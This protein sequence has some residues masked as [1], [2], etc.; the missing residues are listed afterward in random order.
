VKSKEPGC[1]VAELPSCFR[2]G[3]SI[4]V[5]CRD[6]TRWEP[7]AN[8]AVVLAWVALEGH[9]DR[10]R[11]SAALWPDSDAAQAR[12]NLRVLVHRINQK[13]GGELLLGAEHLTLDTALAPLEAQDAD[14][15]LAALSEGGAAR[16]ELLAEAGADASAGEDLR[17][18]LEATRLRQRQ[19]H[20]AQLDEA[21]A[22]ALAS[23]AQPRALALARAG[24]QLDPLSEHRHRRL[25]EVLVRGGDRAAALAAYEACKTVL[26]Q[27]LGVLPGLQTRTVQL[28]ILQ[29]QVLGP[30][31][32]RPQ[33]PEAD[34]LTTL[35]GAARYPLVERE[36]LLVQAQAALERGLHVVVQGEPGVGKTRLLRHL[37]AWAGGDAEPVAIRSAL[38]Q[39][40]YAA[41]AQLLQEV[42]ARRAPPI[43]MPEQIELARLAPLAF[44]GVKPSDAP[45]SVSRLHA[46]LRH[47]LARLGGVGV[48]V[49]V[50]DDVHDADAASQ[51]ALAALLQAPPDAAS[52][53]PALLLG[54]RS[55]EVEPV[56]D[57]TVTDSQTR[58]RVQRIELPRLSQAGV[59]TLLNAMVA[60]RSASE[61]APQALAQQLHKQTGG[62]P[63]FVIELA[64]Q[65]LEQG[66]AADV[67]S[68]QALLR[69]G[70]LRC[71]AIAQQL[72]AVAAVAAEDF[73]VELAVSVTGQP[74]LALMPAWSEL[75]QRGLFAGHGLAHDLVQDAVLAGLPEAIR[76]LLHRQLAQHL[77]DQGM[78]GAPVLRHWQAAG[79][80]DRA[81]P[82]AV[83]QLYAV[84]AAGLSAL[85]QELEIVRLL[86][87]AS[88]AVLAAHLWLTAELDAGL[89]GSCG[90]SAAPAEMEQ[91]R[92]ALRQRVDRGPGHAAHAAWIAYETAHELKWVGLSKRAAYEVLAPAAERMPTRGIERAFVEKALVYLALGLTGDPR[93]HLR[94]ASEAVVALPHGPCVQRVRMEL[95]DAQGMFLD[96][97]EG[98]CTLAARARASRRR[99][100]LAAVA[101]CRFRMGYMQAVLGNASHALRH[102]Q[103]AARLQA[104]DGNAIEPYQS[105]F[106][107]GK[108]ALHAGRYALADRLLAQGDEPAA[109]QTRPVYRAL[110]YLRLGDMAQAR[111][112]LGLV[113]PDALVFFPA[114]AIHTHVRAQLD[115]LEGK[116]P[117]PALRQQLDEAVARGLSGLNRDLMAWELV[118]R[119]Q[120]LATRLHEAHALLRGL[121][122]VGAS[123]ARQQVK[124]LLEIAEACAEA[125]D[126]QAQAL[127]AQA[128]RLLRRGYTNQTLYLPEGLV[129][130]ARLIR[131][132]DP[133]EADALVQVARRWVHGALQ[134]LPAGARDP[135]VQH[136]AVNRLLLGASE[137]A[138]YAAPLC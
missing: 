1:W 96:H 94:R 73:T 89:G 109:R 23:S 44:A 133:R 119:T 74:A 113:G 102:Y 124:A 9:A 24:V 55:G 98:L 31:P 53:S 5:V 27:H 65:A 51:A 85:A 22:Q 64:R 46:A 57:N 59:Q 56:L 36:T 19:A 116:D 50:L 3:S 38:K 47:W 72:A 99:G 45:L 35:G 101:N 93:L 132:H 68:L 110:L 33:T 80:A 84:N 61:R 26:R 105:P 13:F 137:P 79:D 58:H 86:E 103:Q 60:A 15:I 125:G 20:L 111:A 62:N 122:R 95:E 34:G 104:G 129:R 54:H 108:Y 130:C 100:D 66:E 136:V 8:A 10:R 92:R 88:D 4:E 112:Q 41:V 128:A 77:E 127:I 106:A 43:E 126:A 18:W 138:L 12:S 42:Q 120:P 21:L 49:L 131:P 14:A 78:R 32:V 121:Q 2:V 134:H 17:A 7:K 52:P 63:L 70:L 76:H 82:H 37:A 25:M 91:R 71:G 81:L 117:V 87:R 90:G 11:L 75:Q 29:E 28:R 97:V 6:G 135:F 40:P 69:A 123:G 114:Q 107:V 118:Q 83:H 48:R 30:A 115:R 67:G 16:C 39:E